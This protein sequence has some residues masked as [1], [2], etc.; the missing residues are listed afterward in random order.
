MSNRMTYGYEGGGCVSLLGL[1]PVAGP[2]VFASGVAEMQ[3]LGGE[4]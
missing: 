3:M 1:V 2:D 4:N